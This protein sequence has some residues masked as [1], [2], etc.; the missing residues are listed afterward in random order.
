MN[1]TQ[2]CKYAEDTTLYVGGKN[3]IT[4]VV[5]LEKDTLLLSKWFSNNLMKLNDDKCHLLIF[6]AKN[7]GVTINIGT[8]EV[9]ESES[10]K[11]LGVVIDSKVEV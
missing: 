1:N 3:Y 6:G 10:L 11:L 8:I 5:K 9:S 4:M 7:Q 2:V